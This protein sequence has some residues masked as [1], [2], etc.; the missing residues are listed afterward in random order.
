[1]PTLY[2]SADENAEFTFPLSVIKKPLYA[3]HRCV[4]RLAY[5]AD[6]DHPNW[7]PKELS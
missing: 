2:D 3:L 5:F 1:M 6:D 4:D 7:L